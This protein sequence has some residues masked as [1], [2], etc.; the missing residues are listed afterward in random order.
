MAWHAYCRSTR[1]FQSGSTSMEIMDL[2]YNMALDIL[3]SRHYHGVGLLGS[4]RP[5]RLRSPRLERGD[6]T[7]RPSPALIVGGHCNPSAHCNITIPTMWQRDS[8]ES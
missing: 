8:S 7:P 4:A 1:L 5:T 2:Q 3:N 6:G